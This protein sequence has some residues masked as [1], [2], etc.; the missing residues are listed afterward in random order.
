V[1]VRIR[2]AALSLGIA[3]RRS[4]MAARHSSLNGRQNSQRGNHMT[5]T[6][7]SLLPTARVL[8]LAVLFGPPALSAQS[9]WFRDRV[10][11][12]A[13]TDLVVAAV[14]EHSVTLAWGPSTDN[15]GRFSYIIC[16]APTNVIVPQTVTSHT[17][18]GLQSGKQYTFR[19]YA[20]D[21]AGNLSK[22]SN[23]VTVTL[24]GELA[25]PTKPVVQLLEVGP[26][27]A[28]L[29]WLSTDDGP[30][31]WYTIYVDG[32][33]VRTLNSTSSTFTCAQTL[34]PTS[35]VPFQ[36]DT[37]Y[38]FTVRARDV[39]GNNSP[40]SDP[41]F[42]RTAPAPDDHTPPTQPMNITADGSGFAIVTWDPSTDDIAP[43]QF[44]R[45]DIYVNGELRTVVVGASSA[46]VE[47][48]YGLTT[49]SIIAVDTAGNES[50][51]GTIVVDF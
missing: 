31:I 5:H 1:A 26:T 22:S 41:V 12:T 49:I 40:F 28:R 23:P 29:S 19:V 43:Q 17:L 44:I 8:V 4:R 9:S 48:D 18:E 15:S 37:E 35:C 30:Y 38:T 46:E 34:V 42:V 39:N 14:T 32:Q 10:P 21:A 51:P 6:L 3:V 50:A 33:P 24:P 11:P 16:C 20:R 7:V 45:Y 13:P 47:V 36:P 27:H 2:P 25:A